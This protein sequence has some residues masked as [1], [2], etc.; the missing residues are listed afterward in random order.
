[1]SELTIQYLPVSKIIL[2]QRNPRV[3][4]ALES[5]EGDPRKISLN[6]LLGS[7]P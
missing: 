4:P 3:A 6:S 2:D 1:M 5:I 7:S